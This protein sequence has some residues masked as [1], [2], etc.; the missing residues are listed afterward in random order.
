MNYQ[1]AMYDPKPLQEARG[2]LQASMNLYDDPKHQERMQEEME[3]VRSMTAE[4]APPWRTFWEKK[5]KPAAAAIYHELL[6]KNYP[7]TPSAQSE[8]Y[9]SK[10]DPKYRQG[11]L[12]QYPEIRKPE[13]RD[14]PGRQSLETRW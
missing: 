12:P 5:N 3:Q 13:T 9:L 2:L 7:D 4:K 1:G 6:L 11:I 10:I 8:E 14:R